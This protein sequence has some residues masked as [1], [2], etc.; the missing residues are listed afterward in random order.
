MQI[1]TYPSQY[2]IMHIYDD[3]PLH[4]AGY[5]LGAFLI[6]THLCLL[7]QESST[8]AFLQKFH[9]NTLVGTILMWIAFLWFWLYIIPPT[10]FKSPLAMDLGEDFNRLKPILFYV[11]PV[12]A[13][14]VTTEVKEFLAVRALGFLCLLAAL[15]LLMAAF[16]QPQLSSLLIPIYSYGILTAG[17]FFV[18]VPYVF[19]DAVQWSTRTSARWKALSLSGLAYGVAVLASAILFW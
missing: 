12:V 9:R 11:V 14:L 19:R 18:G 17:M 8:K 2:K 13:Y 1:L 6:G 16:Q 3:I 5:A 4:L 10:M 15:P 7:T